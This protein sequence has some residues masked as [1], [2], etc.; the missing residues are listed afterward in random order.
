V[1]FAFGQPNLPL[2]CSRSN[3]VSATE[4]MRKDFSPTSLMIQTASD[5]DPWLRGTLVDT[6]AHDP[7]HTREFWK[8]FNEC[9]LL[10]SAGG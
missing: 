10:Q 6:S 5:V 3:R 4:T 9:T 2:W 7:E 1:P 8:R